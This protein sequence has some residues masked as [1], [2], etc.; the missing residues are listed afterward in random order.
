MRSRQYTGPKPETLLR[1]VT[2]DARLVELTNVVID[3]VERNVNLK[4]PLILIFARSMVGYV[5][6]VSALIS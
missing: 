5:S 2:Q 4:P 3:E 6:V 1:L